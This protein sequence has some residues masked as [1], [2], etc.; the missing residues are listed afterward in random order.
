MTEEACLVKM[1][2]F[3]D[4]MNKGTVN[5]DEFCR[6]LEKTGMYYPRQQLATLFNNYDR[7]QNGS[8]DYREL[9]FE[10]FGEYKKPQQQPNRPLPSQDR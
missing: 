10:L 1:F 8:L 4:V 6:V 5:F 9:A 7:D 2:K 3:F